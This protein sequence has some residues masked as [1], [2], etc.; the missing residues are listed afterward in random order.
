MSCG[1]SSLRWTT[2]Y[3]TTGTINTSDARHKMNVVSSN[4]GLN[5]ISNLNPIS[6]SWIDGGTPA[7]EPNEVGP[8]PGKRTFYG[9][10][11]Q[12]VKK[13]LD[14]LG[15]GDFGGWT[16]DDPKD[17]DSLQGLRYTEFISPMVKAIQELSAQVAALE[18]SLSSAVATQASLQAQVAALQGKSP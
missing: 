2:V 4:L 5:F 1:F 6:Y 11:A 10:L 18:Q 13:T 12:D 15:T 3:A 9:F 8:R 16:L 7:T 17:P 14:S